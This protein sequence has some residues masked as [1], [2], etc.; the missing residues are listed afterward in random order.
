M[1]E[2]WRPSGAAIRFLQVVARRDFL[3]SVLHDLG[4]VEI[5]ATWLLL[6]KLR[7]RVMLPSSLR[8]LYARQLEV[9]A[10]A[11]AHRELAMA[12][13]TVS[14]CDAPE[15][16]VTIDG[17]AVPVPPGWVR[18]TIVDTIAPSQPGENE[19]SGHH[20]YLYCSK[21][22]ATLVLIRSPM[23]AGV[24]LAEQGR[25]ADAKKPKPEPEL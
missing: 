10:F 7:E 14:R 1:P 17:P 20:Q 23:L 11:R 8:W 13:Q 4:S 25:R 16:T 6:G 5:N 9:F 15:C 2:L 3:S 12:E 18:R 19:F 21:H 24:V 22:A